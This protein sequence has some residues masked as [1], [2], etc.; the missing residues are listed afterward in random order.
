MYLFE[1]VFSCFFSTYIPRS[2]IDL[3]FFCSK[4]V[5]IRSVAFTDGARKLL[6]VGRVA[7][8]LVSIRSTV[9]KVQGAHRQ[10]FVDAYEKGT[11]LL[12]ILPRSLK[13]Q[14]PHK[15][16]HLPPSPHSDG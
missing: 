14:A 12:K 3:T 7:P 13:S 10:R 9:V 1:L 2:G 16:S 8:L 11:C 6:E 15:S 5:L 4:S